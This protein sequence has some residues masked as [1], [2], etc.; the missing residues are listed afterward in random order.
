MGSC[1]LLVSTLR[2]FYKLRAQNSASS[3]SIAEY[4]VMFPV[5]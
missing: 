3:I 2:P 4:V 5:G 1:C